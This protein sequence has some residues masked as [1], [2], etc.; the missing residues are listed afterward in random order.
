MNPDKTEAVVIGTGARQRMEGLVNTV[1]LGCAS[2]SPASSVRSLGVTVDNTLSF[3]EH[4]DNVCK[5]C[6]FHILALRHIRRHISEDAAKTI[7]CSM[8]GGRLDHCNSVLYHM[9]VSNIKK[10]QLVQN[11]IAR[12]FTGWRLSNHITPVLADLHWLPVQYR[13]QCKLAVITFKVLTTHEPSYLH[14]LIQL[15]APTRQLRSDRRSLLHV[16]RVKS[17]FAEQAFGHSA[18]AIWNSLPSHLTTDPST[19]STFKRQLKTELYHRAFL[20]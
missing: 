16:D 1:D 19:L 14:N 17:V 3:N 4:V 2:V 15:H 13:I 10:L 20:R 11:S 6:T 9:S 7:A 8:I 12:I 5:S 18:A